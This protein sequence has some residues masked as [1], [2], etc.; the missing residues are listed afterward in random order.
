[1]KLISLLEKFVAGLRGP[2]AD[3]EISE[4]QPFPIHLAG[5]VVMIG[6]STAAPTLIVCPRGAPLTGSEAA[7]IGVPNAPVLLPDVI[8]TDED[9]RAL[10]GLDASMAEA[11]AG[12]LSPLATKTS[13]DGHVEPIFQFYDNSGTTYPVPAPP[14]PV[15]P[16]GT[17]AENP[18]EGAPTVDAPAAPAESPAVDASSADS[19]VSDSG[20]SDSG[21]GADGGSD[22]G[23]GGGE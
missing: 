7:N 11:A 13:P 4:S 14:E 21:S 15:I 2:Q 3:I 17:P 8:L 9:E 16:E 12:K 5:D 1:M 18:M 10:T 6:D 20:G 19:S 23:S 22:G